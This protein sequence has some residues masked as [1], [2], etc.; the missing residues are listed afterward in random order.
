MLAL[1]LFLG[2]EQLQ[3][4]TPNDCTEMYQHVE[5]LQTGTGLLNGISS[6]ISK[7]SGL[8]TEFVKRCSTKMN[9][10]HVSCSLEQKS[11]VGVDTCVKDVFPQGYSSWYS[12]PSQ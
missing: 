1:L 10:K 6:T 9:K 8:E 7:V 4:A 12:Q 5:R 3:S 11:I 2:C